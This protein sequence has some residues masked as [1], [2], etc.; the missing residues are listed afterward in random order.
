MAEESLLSQSGLQIVIEH[1]QLMEVMDCCFEERLVGLRL[2]RGVKWLIVFQ[3]EE[4]LLVF[5]IEWVI[6]WVIWWV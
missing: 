6:R 5:L 4:E 2:W 1:H 3:L